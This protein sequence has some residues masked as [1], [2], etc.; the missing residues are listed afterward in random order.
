MNHDPNAPWEAVPD[1]ERVEFFRLEGRRPPSHEPLS[2]KTDPEF[3]KTFV[4]SFR[5]EVITGGVVTSSETEI[6]FGKD[7]KTP[8][9]TAV[10]WIETKYCVKLELMT[11]EDPPLY[12]GHKGEE[13]FILSE[14]DFPS[15]PMLSK[16][17]RDALPPDEE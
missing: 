3:F 4:G 15:I 10:E 14:D 5:L 1:P 17:E 11:G 8:F 12:T 16:A 6:V 2:L 9:E 7:G 13:T